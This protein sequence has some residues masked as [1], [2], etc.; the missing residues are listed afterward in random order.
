MPAERDPVYILDLDGTIL[1]KNSFPHWVMYLARAPFSDLEPARRLRVSA[2]VFA[3]LVGRKIG[4]TRH[5][6]F[7]RRLQT[8]WQL[9]T[10]DDEG[11]AAR[12]FADRMM[13]HVR[14]ELSPIL[15]AVASGVVDAILATAAPADYA[16]TLGAALGFRHILATGADRPMGDAGNVG[17]RKRL[18]V[19]A[20]LASNGWNGRPRVLFTDHRDDLP[21]IAA[22][23]RTYWFGPESEGRAIAASMP[24]VS[25]KAG[26]RL[27]S[28]IRPFQHA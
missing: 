1:S 17:E 12:A 25:L 22:C 9:A 27:A 11:R 14:P 26:L 18:A 13:R 28:D 6:D 23:D 8:I 21:L 5:E 19:L 4:A 3:L 7:K 16:E 2:A 20:L 24:G 15:R 10:K